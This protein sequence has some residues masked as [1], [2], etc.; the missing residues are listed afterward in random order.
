MTCIDQ[1]KKIKKEL[2]ELVKDLPSVYDRIGSSMANMGK[3]TQYYSTFVE[4]TLNK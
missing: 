3:A 4:F 2:V 1:G